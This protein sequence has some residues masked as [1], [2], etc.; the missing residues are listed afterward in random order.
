MSQDGHTEHRPGYLVKRVQ[1]MLRHEAERELRDN[2]VTISQ[3]AVLNALREHPGASSAELARRCFVTRQSLQ[4]VLAGL[5]GG[6]LV[7]VADRPAAGRA[8]PARLTPLGEQRLARAGEVMT[9]AEE[10]MLAGFDAEERALLAGLLIRC[11]DNLA[12]RPE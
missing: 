10:R 6:G 2:G 11:T 5:R 1:Q 4:D 8:K 9:A 12:G 7:E 3:Y